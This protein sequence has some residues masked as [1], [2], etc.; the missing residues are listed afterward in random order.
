[1]SGLPYWTMDIGGFSV[2]Q[3]DLKNQMPTDLEEWREL[4]DPLVPVWCI[5]SVVPCAWTVSVI[6]RF[7]NTA[8]DDHPAYQSHACIMI[9]SV[10]G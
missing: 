1:M 6:V 5:C 7:I 3:K 2:A 8:P 9:S 10:T 4:N